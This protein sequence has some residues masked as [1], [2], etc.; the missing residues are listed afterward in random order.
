MNEEGCLTGIGSEG[1]TLSAV[2][3]ASE[4]VATTLATPADAF[5]AGLNVVD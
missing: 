2:A 5:T 3:V 1:A 4:G